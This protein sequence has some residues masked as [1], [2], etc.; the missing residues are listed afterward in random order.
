[1]SEGAIVFFHQG[2]IFNLPKTAQK[3]EFVI[4]GSKA[5]VD[6]S[7]IAKVIRQAGNGPEQ[8]WQTTWSG[9]L[10]SHQC[11]MAACGRKVAVG[12]CIY[13]LRDLRDPVL[14]GQEES[15][16]PKR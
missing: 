15:L 16:M 8:T 11:I 10:P 13:T 1:M 4:S 7:P 14:L 2:N 9:V 3:W 12:Y 6:S 5:K